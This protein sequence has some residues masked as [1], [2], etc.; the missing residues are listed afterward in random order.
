V[1]GAGCE[2]AFEHT[3]VRAHLALRA[4]VIDD[5]PID[6]VVDVVAHGDVEDGGQQLGLGGE[7]T[8]VVATARAEHLVEVDA[9]AR[10]AQ[11]ERHVRQDV[12]ERQH[13]AG[14][15]VAEAVEE[16]A[17]V[18]A[19]DRHAHDYHVD[20]YLARGAARVHALSGSI[21]QSHLATI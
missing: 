5:A 3:C 17:G 8:D 4:R 6:D 16:L 13:D 19:G 20:P 15:R 10:D 12:G 2:D 14:H 1:L 18:A 7:Q 21:N 11:A 9:A